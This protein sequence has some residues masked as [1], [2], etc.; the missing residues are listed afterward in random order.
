MEA[1]YKIA[2]QFK[3][4]GGALELVGVE[5]L[6]P[7]GSDATSTLKFIHKIKDNL[8]GARN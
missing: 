1:L 5:D 4:G 3:Q 8:L 6:K 7:V 2:Y